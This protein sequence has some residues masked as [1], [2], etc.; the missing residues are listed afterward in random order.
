MA[1]LNSLSDEELVSRIK[2]GEML[3]FEELVERYEK[4]ILGFGVRIVGDA[5]EA[6]EITQETLVSAYKHLES[7]DV[8]KKFSSWIFQIAKNKGMDY[9]R[10]KARLTKLGENVVDKKLDEIEELALKEDEMTVRNAVENLPEMQKK[11][12]QSFYFDNLTYEQI[13]KKMRLPINTVRSHL[14][15]AKSALK[16]AIWRQK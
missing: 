14:F 5:D 4:R 15:R 7:F 8:S 12:V 11:V 10:R 9:W 1:V 3:L 2:K 13:S 6:A 16:K